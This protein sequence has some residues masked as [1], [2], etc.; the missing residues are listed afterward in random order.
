MRP[1]LAPF[2]AFGLALAT[3]PAAAQQDEGWTR[4]LPAMAPGLVACLEGEAGGVVTAAMPMN[5][6]RVLVRLQ[7]PGGER[8]E[9]VAELGPPGRPARRE[10]LRPVGVEPPWPGEDG[11]RFTL[12]PLCAGAAGM[13]D[14]A[15]QPAGWLNPEGC[16]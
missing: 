2:M 15:G 14:E 13:R 10:T 8:L 5:H 12:H 11:R 9:C 16:G 1:R 4:F 6:G 3:L 7:R